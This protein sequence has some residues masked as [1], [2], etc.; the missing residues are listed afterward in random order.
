M[1]LLNQGDHKCYSLVVELLFFGLLASLWVF[2]CRCF[3]GVVGTYILYTSSSWTGFHTTPN[4]FSVAED[5]S[6]DIF[7][8]DQFYH[9]WKSTLSL[10]IF[11]RKFCRLFFGGNTLYYV[12]YVR[13]LFNNLSRFGIFIHPHFCCFSQCNGSDRPWGLVSKWDPLYYTR[14]YW[15]S[16]V[17]ISP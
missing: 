7:V 11:P 15:S 16:S 3:L 10:W 4:T 8:V 1:V 13:V 17:H 5:L 12:I 6:L 9:G 2:S 14:V